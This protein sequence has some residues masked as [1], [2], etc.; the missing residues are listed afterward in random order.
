MFEWLKALRSQPS[1]LDE[2]LQYFEQMLEDGR[3]TFDAATNALMGGT[4]P[5]TIK[6]DLWATDERTNSN[7]KRIRHRLMT[8]CAVL[9]Q[10]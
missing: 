8:Q 2:I 10:F 7:E 4:D 5:A 1:G 6:D 3:H 9:A